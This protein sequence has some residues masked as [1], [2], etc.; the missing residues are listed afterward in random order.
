M[1]FFPLILL[2]LAFVL[3]IVMPA[4]QRKRMAAQQQQM[5]ESL[6]PGTPIMTTSGIHGTVAGKTDTTVDVQVAPGVVMT[7]AR[8]AILEVRTPAADALPGA[9]ATSGD[10]TPG[11]VDGGPAG[12]TR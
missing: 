6:Q 2:V 1:E 11:I 9:D 12:T 4:R 5:Q 8:Q 3:L 7:F 10:D